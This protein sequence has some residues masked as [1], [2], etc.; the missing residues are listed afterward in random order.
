MLSAKC[1]VLSAEYWVLSAECWVLSADCWVLNSDYW[2]LSACYY[3]LQ[4][5]EVKKSI[6]TTSGMPRTEAINWRLQCKTIQTVMK[7]KYWT[8]K[9]WVI[10]L[11]KAN[12]R[13]VIIE[14]WVLSAECWVLSAECWLL[15]AKYAR[16]Y[17]VFLLQVA[18]QKFRPQVDN[19]FFF[20]FCTY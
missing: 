8:T 12:S 14:S 19:C 18:C 2:V 11:I 5:L 6:S 4:L 20:L 1:W 13:V 15:Q 17:F 9:C 16:G 10:G 7:A 3:N